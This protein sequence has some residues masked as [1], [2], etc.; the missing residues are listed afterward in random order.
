MAR[1]CCTL[2]PLLEVLEVVMQ[3]MLDVVLLILHLQ[4]TTHLVYCVVSCCR[5]RPKKQTIHLSQ[6]TGLLLHTLHL[7]LDMASLG[8]MS[9]ERARRRS[10]VRLKF[11]KLWL[12]RCSAIKRRL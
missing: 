4:D 9:E 10:V 11:V 6:L 7:F 12:P 8:K 1:G 3:I 5:V 2:Y